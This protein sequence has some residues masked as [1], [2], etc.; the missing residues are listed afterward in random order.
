MVATET[1]GENPT[2]GCETSSKER[3]TGG[4]D[5]IH[6]RDVAPQ[7]NSVQAMWPVQLHQQD[8]TTQGDTDLN[9]RHG[10]RE[11]HDGRGRGRL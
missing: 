7:Q 9:L 10:H 11:H 4:R 2:E 6:H 3:S 1:G 5:N 8:Q